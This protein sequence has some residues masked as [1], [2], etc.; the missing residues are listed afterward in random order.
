MRHW[1]FWWRT[2]IFSTQHN[3][4]E[5]IEH[6]MMFLAFA[7]VVRWGITY[8]WPY[9]VLSSSFALGAAVSIGI[10]EMLVN[11]HRP[12]AAIIF[13]VA[14]LVLYSLY[15]FDILRDYF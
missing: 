15:T 8:E 9:L 10:R 7:L 1:Q 14:G 3:P 5:F 2:L 11:S 6:L 13:V 4:H 12:R